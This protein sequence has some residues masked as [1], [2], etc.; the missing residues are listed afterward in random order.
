MAFE[1]EICIALETAIGFEYPEIEDLICEVDE[2]GQIAIEFKDD[3]KHKG[4]MIR[5]YVEK[6]R[7]QF[8]K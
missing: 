1:N 3:G 6:L 4:E 7:Q 5:E 8:K 2:K